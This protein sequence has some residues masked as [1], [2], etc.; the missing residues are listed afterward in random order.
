MKNI[1]LTAA[2]LFVAYC[3]LVPPAVKPA[4]PVAAALQNASS[5]DRAE[6]AGIYRALA[7]VIRRDGGKKITTTVVWRLVYRD[8]LSLAAGGTDLPGKYKGLDTAVEEVL[9]KYYSLDAAP[10]DG[11][12]A[13]KIATGC[14]EVVRQSGG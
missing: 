14:M 13:E 7:D 10:I 6:V 8:A 1:A 2:G 5:T 4:G 9:A 11:E 12:L 3:F